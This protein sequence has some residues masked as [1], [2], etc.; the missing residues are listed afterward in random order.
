MRYPSRLCV[1]PGPWQRA[2]GLGK[3]GF[4][5][6]EQSPC[7][8]LRLRHGCLISSPSHMYWF[9]PMFLSK[10]PGEPWKVATH[11]LHHLETGPNL[12]AFDA[13]LTPSTWQVLV[14]YCGC[15]SETV[16][17]F[18]YLDNPS[19]FW[20]L[21]PALCSTVMLYSLSCSSHLAS[22]PSGPRKLQSQVL[23][24]VFTLNGCPRR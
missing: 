20:F 4:V 19:T 9:F 2:T 1:W 24:S 17:F 12:L 18:W 22:C 23:W 14:F 8:W 3:N 6:P 11:Y 13:V 10:P 5:G 7:G 21:T 16:A 15:I